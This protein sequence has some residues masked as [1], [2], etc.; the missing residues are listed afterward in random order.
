VGYLVAVTE[1]DLPQLSSHAQD[2]N[3]RYAHEEGQYFHHGHGHRH[4]Q[5]LPFA[6]VYQQAGV[7]Y[8]KHAVALDMDAS[9]GAMKSQIVDRQRFIMLQIEDL[10]QDAEEQLQQ[11]SIHVSTLDPVLRKDPTIEVEYSTAA[12]PRFPLTPKLPQTAL[13]LAKTQQE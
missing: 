5:D 4:A 6:F 13:A 7:H 11:L 8:F 9:I 2:M 12:A 3:S 10:L 1:S